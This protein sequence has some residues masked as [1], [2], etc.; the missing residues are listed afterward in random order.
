MGRLLHEFAVTIVVAIIISGIVSVTLTPMLCARVLK[1]DDEAHGGVP[2]LKQHDV[3]KLAMP[4]IVTLP[5][6][7]ATHN[8]A[9]PPPACRLPFIVK[10]SP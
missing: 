4:D 9:V 3:Q 8:S 6:A 7:F 1:H 10:V 5:A 2:C